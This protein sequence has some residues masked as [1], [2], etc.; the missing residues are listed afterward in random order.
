MHYRIITGNNNDPL[1]IC[2]GYMFAL[3]YNVK[4]SFLKS[5]DGALM[6]DPL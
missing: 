4:S 1:P 3:P 2:H 6:E 5:L